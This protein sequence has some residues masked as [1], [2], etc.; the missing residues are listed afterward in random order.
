MGF[1]TDLGNVA[2]GAIERD[3]EITKEDLAIRAENLQANRQILIN[4]K[5]KKY[6]KELESFYKEKEKYDNINKMN[7]MFANN[8]IDKG[9]Y[10]SFALSSSIPNWDTLPKDKKTDLIDNFDGKTIDYKLSGSVEEINK[11]AAVAQTLINN[12]TSAAIKDAKGNSFL[13]NQ[14]LGRKETQEKDLYKAIESKL[15]AAEAVKMTEKGTENSGLE[16]KMEGNKTGDLNWKK[17]IKKNPDW[18]KRYNGLKDK[19]VYKS[20]SQNNNFLNFITTSDIMGASSEGN[21]TLKNNDTE[22]EGLNDSA[23]AMLKT[24]EMVYNSVVNDFYAKEL[25]A[26]NVDITQL[27]N[28]VSL[29]EVNKKVQNIIEQRGF[30][31]DLGDGY[32]DGNQVDFVGIVP[33]NIVDRNGGFELDSGAT[34]YLNMQ[35]VK[36]EYQTFLETEADKLI[37]SSPKRFEESTNKKAAAMS[38]VQA[39]IE[40]GGNY[41]SMF[42]NSLKVDRDDPNTP[43]N[44]NITQNPKVLADEKM[45]NE[46]NSVGSVVKIVDDGKGNMVFRPNDKGKF[47]GIRIMKDGTGFKQ[48]QPN[49][50]WKKVSWQSVK[51]GNNVD[52]LSPLMKLKYD[53]WLA[54][55]T[56]QAGKSVTSNNINSVENDQI[57]ANIVS[58]IEADVTGKKTRK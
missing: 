4:Q 54:G 33:L 1:L 22:I 31:V 14:I 36:N 7:T 44:E 50:N 35:Y 41:S 39:S 12:E 13:I 45:A 56:E 19:I 55:N 52:K 42:K 30:R 49:G 8:E 32:G 40:N 57:F 20:A 6:D 53:Q 34:K 27:D 24:Y 15:N 21:F 25:A 47:K 2:V 29:A 10:A 23:R 38:V 58:E 46:G 18:I 16:V 26:N 3:R 17:F 51:D 43:E 5:Q 48:K 28:F 11:K 37:S 9:T